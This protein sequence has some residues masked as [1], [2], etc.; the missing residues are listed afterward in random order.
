MKED[1]QKALKRL[2]FKGQDNENQKGPGSSDQP[3]FRFQDK[4]LKI[5]LLRMYYLTKY[6]NVL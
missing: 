5:P 4:F 1:D 6:N 3:L 2:T